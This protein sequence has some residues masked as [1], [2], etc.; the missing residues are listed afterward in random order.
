MFADLFGDGSAFGVRISYF[1]EETPLGTAGALPLLRDRLEEDF[2][3]VFGDVIF[4][5]D[6]ARMQRFHREKQADATLFVHP[7]THPFDSDVILKDAQGRIEGMYFKNTARDFWYDNCV[8]AGFYLLN[9]RIVEQL[10]RGEKADLERDLLLPLVRQGK[11]VYA[12]ASP[13]YIKDVGTPQRIADAARELERGFVQARCLNRPQ[14]CIFLDR[15]G[16]VNRYKG[17]LCKEEDLE[18]EESAVEAIRCI[19]QAGWLAIVVT[20]QPVVARGMCGIDDVERIHNKMKTLLGR[21]GVYLD[22]VRFCPHHPD[23]GFPEENPAYKIPCTCRKPD[24]GMLRDCAEA[25]H[26]DLAQSWMVGD[27]TVDLETGRNA[28]THTA[29]V[30]TGLAGKDGKYSAEAEITAPD[31]L[32]AVEQILH[33]C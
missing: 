10:P 23:K 13:E 15:D 5:I 2:L 3:L 33:S 8:N 24:I 25:Y 29:L 28:G 18:L 27:T 12:Y 26:I 7:N 21:E 11:A 4:E 1:T 16:T 30:Q 17:L 32:R 19:N 20:N 22:D 14:R 31:L 9:R 6:L